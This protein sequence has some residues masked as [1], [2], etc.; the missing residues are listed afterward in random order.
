MGLTEY[1][2]HYDQRKERKI[3]VGFIHDE[4]CMTCRCYE[5]SSTYK[6]YTVCT[7]SGDCQTVVALSAF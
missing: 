6:L 1:S 2:Q 4:F 3:T 5:H 7:I